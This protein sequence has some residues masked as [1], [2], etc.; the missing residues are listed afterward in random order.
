MPG[1]I[2][3]TVE[4]M[5][6]WPTPNYINPETRPNTITVLALVCGTIN[7]LLLL[8]RLWVRIFHQRNPGWDDWIILAATIPTA[9]MTVMLPIAA[10]RGFSHHVWDINPIKDS[11]KVV[12]SRKFVLALECTFCVASGMIK[13]SILLFYRRLSSRVVSTAFRWTT[14][15][16]IGCIVAYTIA[17]TLAPILGCQP[18]SAFWDQVDINK[19]LNGYEYHCFDEGADVFAASVISAAQDLITAI[20]PTFLYWK[21]QMPLRQKFALFGIFGIGYGVVALGGLRAYYSWYTF[22]ET[23]DITWSTWDLMLVT[24]L[25]LHVGAFCANSP[26]LKVFFKHF[27]QDKLSSFSRSK[28]PNSSKGRKDSAHS[29][30]KVNKSRTHHVFDKMASLL[31]SSRSTSGY[32]SEPHHSVA[33]DAQGGVQVQKEVHVTRSP[34]STANRHQSTNTNESIYDHYYDDIELGRYTTGRNSQASSNRST[35]VVEDVDLSA[36]PPMPTSPSS[37]SFKSFQMLIPQLHVRHEVPQLP[38]PVVMDAR[39]GGGK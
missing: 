27:F 36:L 32:I 14:W 33:V 13:I 29:G 31:G 6:S 17:L 7:V 12:E 35:R 2:H 10:S 25:E 30:S 11:N 20:L 21:L 15:I 39:S 9:A 23:Y 26:S 4:V 3:P 8:A 1:G 18:V 28:T 38:K 16:T 5:L 19:R 34:L 24:L 37:R 22:Y